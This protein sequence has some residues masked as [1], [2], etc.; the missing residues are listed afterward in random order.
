MEPEGTLPHSQV[1]TTCPCPEPARS[2]PYPTSHFLKTH[3]NIIPC[4]PRSPQWCLSLRFP[5]QNPVHVSPLPHTRHMPRP[6]HSSRFYHLHNIGRSLTLLKKKVEVIV[7]SKQ[8]GPHDFVCTHHT[9]H[10]KLRVMQRSFV[11]NM[12]IF[13]PPVSV[14]C[15][16][17]L[18]V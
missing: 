13:R 5:H 9:S 7:S 6:S 15:L 3:L 17:M 4:M 18:R 2:S 11:N 12:R 14:L 16:L 8:Q 10:S 1:P